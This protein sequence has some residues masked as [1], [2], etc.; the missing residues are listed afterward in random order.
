MGRVFVIH[1][2]GRCYG[3]RA[4]DATALACSVDEFGVEFLTGEAHLLRGGTILMRLRSRMLF[5]R[6]FMI[7]IW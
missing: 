2:G 6:R 3:V 5:A 7:R 1:L 4:A